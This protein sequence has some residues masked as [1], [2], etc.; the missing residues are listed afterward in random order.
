MAFKEQNANITIIFMAFYVDMKIFSDEKI[1][2]SDFTNV[3]MKKA[4]FK[5][6]FFTRKLN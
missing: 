2:Y 4:F 5:K 6:Y 3:E 1:K